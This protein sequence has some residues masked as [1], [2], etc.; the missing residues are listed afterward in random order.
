MIRIGH[1]YDAHRFGDL[2]H[3]A[4]QQYIHIGGVKI[5][6]H[7]ALLAHSDGDVL[8]HAF[9]DALLGALALGDIGRYFPDT[10]EL[11]KNIDSRQL[12]VNVIR[13]VTDSGYQLG[14]A[15]ITII[16]QSPR[17]F[18]FIE[19]MQDNLSHD[20]LCKPSQVNVKATTTEKMGFTG[21]NEGIAV[22]AVVLL[23]KS[24]H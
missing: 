4:E 16:A 8:I 15:D 7:V 5:S 18:P 23:I 11:Y 1:G 13:K 2:S 6:H 12:L 24:K 9:C 19:Q 17:M 20:C 14:N 3:A 10:D 22:H 21:R